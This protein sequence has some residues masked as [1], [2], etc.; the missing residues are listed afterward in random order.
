MLGVVF[1]LLFLFLLFLVLGVLLFRDSSLICG[2]RSSAYLRHK[3]A[4][5]ES[6]QKEQEQFLHGRNR[7]GTDVGCQW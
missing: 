6:H 5:R 7:V 3:D 2:G 4:Q 1:V